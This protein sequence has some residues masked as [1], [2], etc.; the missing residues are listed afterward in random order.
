MVKVIRDEIFEQN[1]DSISKNVADRFEENIKKA[2]F[3]DE[4]ILV[5]YEYGYEH[6]NP[7]KF[8]FSYRCP[9]CSAKAIEILEEAMNNAY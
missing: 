8:I 3:G 4:A 2:N 9:N 5:I 6:H 7:E 1:F